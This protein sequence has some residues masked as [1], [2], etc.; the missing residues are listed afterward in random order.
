[1][2]SNGNAT[3]AHLLDAMSGQRAVTIRYRKADGTVSRRTIELLSVE[4]SGAGNITLVAMDRRSGERRT[5]RLDRVTHYT[6]HRSARLA[7]YRNP[8]D[9]S[10]QPE[11]RDE[12]DEVVAVNAWT[13]RYVL[14]A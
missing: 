1:M 10:A 12:D 7:G 3:L 13:P 11:C 2:R 6:L 8:V 9:P 5:F 14:A 4:V